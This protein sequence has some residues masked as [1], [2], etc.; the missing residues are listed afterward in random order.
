MKTPLKSLKIYDF[1]KTIYDGDASIDFYFYCLRSRPR[2]IKRL[3]HQLW[4]GL[5]YALR[6]ESKT[7]FKG[8]FFIFLRDLDDLEGRVQNFWNGHKKKLKSWYLAQKR[9]DDLIISAS[10]E[11]LLLPLMNKLKISHLIATKMET[12]TGS[13]DGQNCYGKEKAIRLGHMFPG[14]VVQE[15]YTDSLS[16]LPLLRL[17]AKPY[18]VRGDSL[19]RLEHY[20]RLSPLHRFSLGVF[21]G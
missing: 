14:V 19:I 20:L 3:P 16:D 1:D 11:F 17:A 8:H 5:L 12:T 18:I 9:S 7:A 4:H 6:A 13:I 15:V 2:I 10:P 21:R